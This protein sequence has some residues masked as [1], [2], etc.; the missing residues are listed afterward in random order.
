MDITSKT[1]EESEERIMS[2]ISN[3]KG[4]EN[5]DWLDLVTKNNDL[6]KFFAD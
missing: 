4:N 3:N 1:I 2:I 5:V 6:R